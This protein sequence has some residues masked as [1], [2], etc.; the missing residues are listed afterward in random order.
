MNSQIKIILLA[1]IAMLISEVAFSQS[2][3]DRV[4]QKAKDKIEK[5]LDDKVDQEIDKSL[6]KVENS[7]DSL[8]NT[9]SD[10]DAGIS[11]EA[12]MQNRMNSMLKGMGMSGEPVPIENSY[13]FSKLVQMHIEMYD[14]EENKT[15]N[16]EFITRLNPDKGSLAYEVVSD[17]RGGNDQG[18]FIIDTKNK[19]MI[20]LSDK[21]G[22]K[23]GVVYGLGT[24]FEDVKNTD[25]GDY[26]T[27]E[28]IEDVEF[29]H[30]DIKKTGKTKNIAGYKC[31]QY[32][33]NTD[34]V[35]SEFWITDELKTSDR[36]FFSTLFKTSVMTYGMGY[37]YVMESTSKDKATGST[38]KMQVTKVD[39][40]AS[41]TFNLSNYQI[42]N[43]GTFQMPAGN[44]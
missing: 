25:D 33:Y 37:G 16:G 32:L 3:L 21:D 43:L 39:N 27:D 31:E 29:L 6:D 41:S 10:T 13:S 19:A 22:E 9:G 18:L 35:D 36:D 12:A 20:L 38:S 24:F 1:I 30:P 5:R 2:F 7:I 8:G 34:D 40:N 11:R 14:S 26:Q 4:K 28:T 17:D 42:T 44:E 23:T 15:S